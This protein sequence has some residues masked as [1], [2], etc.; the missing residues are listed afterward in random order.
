MARF[1]QLAPEFQQK[2]IERLIENAGDPQFI[3][4]FNRK[5]G[6]GAAEYILQN[7]GAL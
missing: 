3:A 1:N 6:P 2:A 5:L 4:D 7:M